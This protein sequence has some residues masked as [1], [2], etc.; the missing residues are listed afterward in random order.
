MAISRYT[1]VEVVRDQQTGVRNY[2]TIIFSNPPLSNSDMYII[3]RIGDRLDLLAYRFYGDSTLWW[4][5]GSANNLTDSFNVP[6]GTK[7][8]IPSNASYV[9]DHIRNVNKS[10]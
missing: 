7:L 1:D 5:I 8:R 4:I 9:L 6:P 2:P 3:T 10:R